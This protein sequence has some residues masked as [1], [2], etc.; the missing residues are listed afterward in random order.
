MHR[1]PAAD[2]AGWGIPLDGV[3]SGLLPIQAATRDGEPITVAID[4]R[5]GTI[6]ARVWSLSVGRNTLLLLD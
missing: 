2:D 1:S 4:T 3:D 5:T 6:A